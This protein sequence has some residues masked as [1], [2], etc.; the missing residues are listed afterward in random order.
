MTFSCCVAASYGPH[1]DRVTDD[2][3]LDALE[4]LRGTGPEFDG[5]LANHGPMAAEALVRI[6]GATAVPGW[7]DRYRG[8]LDAAP[9]VVRGIGDEDWHA[10]LGDA[11]LF[12]DWTAYLRREAASATGASCCC[13]GGRGCSPGWPPAPRTG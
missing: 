8:R 11:R 1:T 2:T 3:L 13:A 7:V 4:R 9:E 10:H 12:G 6:G 5:F